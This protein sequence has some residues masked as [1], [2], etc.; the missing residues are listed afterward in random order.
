MLEKSQTRRQD[1]AIRSREGSEEKQKMGS[2][3]AGRT[4]RRGSLRPEAPRRQTSCLFLVQIH[5]PRLV[6]KE[7]SW[8]YL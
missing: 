8:I 7:K 4:E 3:E 5:S 2:L 1:P 6:A